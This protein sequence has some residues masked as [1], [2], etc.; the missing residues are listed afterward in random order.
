MPSLRISYSMGV[1]AMVIRI[2]RCC[3]YHTRMEFEDCCGQYRYDTFH[4]DREQFLRTTHKEESA[5]NEMTATFGHEF[6]RTYILLRRYSVLFNVYSVL[7][8]L[9]CIYICGESQGYI[10]ILRVFQTQTMITLMLLVT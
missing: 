1:T 3:N 5:T 9:Y 8:R 6:N 10:S 4:S 2:R 7:K